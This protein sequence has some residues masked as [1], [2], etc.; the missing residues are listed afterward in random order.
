MGR[1][2]VKAYDIVH[3]HVGN[4]HAFLL[5]ELKCKEWYL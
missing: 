2:I 1:V 4:T 3:M 5:N